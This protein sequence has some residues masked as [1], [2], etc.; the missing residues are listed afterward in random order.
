[1][2]DTPP[3]RVKSIGQRKPWLLTSIASCVFALLG[4]QA[5]ARVDYAEGYEVD[6]DNVLTFISV[7]SSTNSY[8]NIRYNLLRA[9]SDENVFFN[10]L[11][12]ETSPEI[13]WNQYSINVG[14][15]SSLNIDGDTRGVVNGWLR[16]GATPG[17]DDGTYA[18]YAG[19]SSKIFL[20]GD[21]DIQVEHNIGNDVKAPLGAN[22][23]Y[24]RYQSSIEVGK[25]AD[26]DVRLWVLAA[27]P[28]LISAKNG[29]SVV[30]HS[31]KNRLIGSID[32]MD[33]VK[34]NDGTSAN[35]NG[36]IV[37]ITLSGSTSYW[38]GDEKTW[39]NSDAPAFE[40]GD[41]FNVTLKDGAQWTYFGLDYSREVDLDGN[42]SKE[43]SYNAIPKRISKITLDGGIINLFDENIKQT[44][45]EIGLW[46]KL[47]NGEYGIDPTTSHDY[48]RIGNLQGI[49]GIFRMDLN[50]E[51]K[52]ESDI[53]YIEGGSG[54]FF[55]EP[56]NLK[57]LESID[58]E[59]NTLTFA[60]TS[61]NASGVQFQDKVNLEGETLY[62]YELEIASKPIED[63]D[64]DENSYWDKTVSLEDT[65][66]AKFDVE[67]EY[68]GGTNWY[69]RRITMKESTAA[70]AMTGSGYAAYDA[71][72]E[73]DRRDRRLSEAVRNAEGDN[74]L[75]VRVSHGR[76]GIDGQYRWDRSGVHIGFDREIVSGNTL[77]AWFS[78]TKGEADLLD[79][80]G[81]GTSDMTRYELALYDTLTFG[82]QYLDF[83]GRF[84]RVSSEFDAASSAFRT[85][86]DFDQDYAALSAEY[87]MTF[88]HE[89]GFFVEPQM[90]VQA[91]FLKSYDYDSDRGMRVDVDGDTSLLGRAG[92]RA[93][94]S[95]ADEFAA[96]ELY[97][98][99]DVLHQFTDGQ[100]AVFR[101][102]DGHVMETNWGDR[103][104]WGVVGFGGAVS[105]GDAYG[106][107]LDVE[108]AFGGDV[109]NTWLITGRFRYAF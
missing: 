77:G 103:G 18:I 13:C 68:A 43:T 67:E 28:D 19:E 23:L 26:S 51:D 36:N 101:D 34:E 102:N 7:D 59:R 35:N 107:Q 100:D 97:A 14:D 53:L 84:G 64:F 11:R 80:N 76:S 30:F 12:F 95:F 31:E 96:G 73:I 22:M 75:W 33:D 58:P 3:P 104:T 91:A 65:D 45:S 41:E 108:H 55:F 54:N 40:S 32:M 37:Q 24:A 2:I 17:S 72:V 49:G 71:A 98:R 16:Q 81:R 61:K 66:P 109:D 1:M 38:F 39:M 21:V 20:S 52:N 88:R 6:Q 93:G 87:G 42:G 8:S 78:Y 86:G 47:L 5:N 50:A 106:L 62:Q 4:N 82:N 25:N 92:L 10:G 15:N 46:D 74:G 89:S 94:R 60:L 85:T 99:A 105:W 9:S 83:V 90:Q 63:S 29:S 48:V 70:H 79:I 27:Q 57:L 44:W 69:I 56:Y